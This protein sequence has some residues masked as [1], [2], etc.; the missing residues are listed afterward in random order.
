M[1]NVEGLFF[2]YRFYEKRGE[3]LSLSSESEVARADFDGY[4]VRHVKETLA[5]CKGL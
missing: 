4:A 1:V 5:A 2:E 3:Y